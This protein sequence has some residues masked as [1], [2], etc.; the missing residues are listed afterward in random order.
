[1]SEPLVAESDLWQFTGTEH[2]YRHSIVRSVTFTDGAKYLADHAGAYWLLDIVA[3]AQLHTVGLADEYFQAWRLT[4]NA[5]AS[6]TVVCTD[7]NDKELYRQTLAYTDFPLSEITL[8]CC[9]DG[10]L[11][12]GLDWVILLPSEY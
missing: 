10:V 11:G 4:V 12:H 5:D 6:A 7:G 9:R 3:I 2:W 8:Y 1:M